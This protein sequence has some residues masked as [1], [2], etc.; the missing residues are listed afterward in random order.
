MEG[1][2][3]FCKLCIVLTLLGLTLICFAMSS[4]AVGTVIANFPIE[5]SRTQIDLYLLDHSLFPQKTTERRESN[6][7]QICI[8]KKFDIS[9]LKVHKAGSTTLMN[10]FLRFAIENK[11]NIVLPRRS[12]GYGFNYLGYGQTLARDKIVPLPANESY[13]ILCNH[14]VYNREA[15]RSIMPEDTVY[16]G[17]IREPVSYFKS[18]S[19]Y[20]GFY[21]QLQNMSEGRIPQDRIVSEFLKNTSQTKRGIYY[22]NNKMSFDFG[23]P[24]Q[25]FHDDV[26]VEEYIKELDQDFSLVLILEHFKES[27]VL[28]K[29]ILCWNTKDILYVP[30]NAMKNKPSFDLNGNDI[31]NLRKWNSAD[32]K[33]YNYFYKVFIAKIA[34]YGEDFKEEV[35][36]FKSIQEDVKRFCNKTIGYR[37]TSSFVTFPNTKWG[38]AFVVTVKDCKLM[39]EPE[40]P[41]MKRL[42][43]NA[44]TRYNAS[45]AKTSFDTVK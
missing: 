30:L 43:E 11:L 41:M 32:F 18:A 27:L 16:V 25:K 4:G 10:I 28:M 22:V 14:V 12:K 24:N 33:L 5:T 42:I 38:D 2:C 44:W 39:K 45:I 35:E 40:A 21:K 29:R 26:F 15:F 1:E 13:N 23:I 9:F 36:N 31:D 8:K 19:S 6:Y 37:D 3:R 17:I 7:P 20:Y 34:S